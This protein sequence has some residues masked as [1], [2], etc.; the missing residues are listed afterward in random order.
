MKLQHLRYQVLEFERN[1][2]FRRKFESLI[3]GL[4]HDIINE[5]ELMFGIE[6][7]FSVQKLK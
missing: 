2:R 5:L 6:G 4:F 1:L 3:F 7:K